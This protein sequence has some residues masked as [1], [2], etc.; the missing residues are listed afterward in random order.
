VVKIIAR[1]CVAPDRRW[2]LETRIPPASY[3]VLAESRPPILRQAAAKA[4]SR[5]IPRL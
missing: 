3:P 4:D 2:R 1:G 5:P